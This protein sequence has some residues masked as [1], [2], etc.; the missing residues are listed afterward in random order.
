MITK[1]RF[2]VTLTLTDA[3]TGYSI[4]LPKN[5]T[6]ISIQCRTAN[7]LKYGL[8]KADVEVGGSNYWTVK[9][10][11]IDFDS[12]TGLNDTLYFSSDFAGAVVEIRGIKQMNDYAKE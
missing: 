1:K 10:N 3:N 6:D 9:A 5:V 8:N 7:I 4:T 11:S 2:F 12:N